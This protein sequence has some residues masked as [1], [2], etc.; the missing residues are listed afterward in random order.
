MD[1]VIG[2]FTAVWQ[3]DP[4]LAV[5]LVLATIGFV[6]TTAVIVRSVV[7]GAVGAGRQLQTWRRDSGRLA[8]AWEA[9]PELGAESPALVNLL[10]TR[11]RLGRAAVLATVLDLAARGAVSLYQP[12]DN[13]ADTVILATAE[14]GGE[15]NAYER[16]IL[17]E[18]TRAG[19]GARLFDQPWL[20]REGQRRWYRQFRREVRDDARARGLTFVDTSILTRTVAASFVPCSILGFMAGRG[21]I[22]I[23]VF[24]VATVVIGERSRVWLTRQG[25]DRLADWLGLREWLVAHAVFADLPPAATTVWG[26]YLAFGTALEV[27]RPVAR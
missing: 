3:V 1:V 9:T 17:D 27:M 26:R 6:A 20:H 8:R 2:L 22:V 7:R 13:P 19:R 21:A 5:V 16:R 14:I 15:L 18:V 24:V 12:A 10:L 11:G 4:A 25:R 23:L